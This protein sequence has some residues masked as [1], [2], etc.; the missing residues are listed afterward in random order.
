MIIS[1]ISA[2]IVMIGIDS[3]QIIPSEPRRLA[4]PLVRHARGPC[5]TATAARASTRSTRPRPLHAVD[6]AAEHV[7][8]HE[9]RVLVELAQAGRADVDRQRRCGSA[10]PARRDRRSR[11]S[12]TAASARSPPRAWNGPQSGRSYTRR[13][14][15]Q[16]SRMSAGC[17]AASRGFGARLLPVAHR[18]QRRRLQQIGERVDACLDLLGQRSRRIR[19]REAGR[20]AAAAAHRT[21]DRRTR[22]GSWASRRA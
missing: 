19:R 7:G 16:A 1:R 8:H 5:G 3:E 6:L 2:Q 18:R 11:R 10:A 15:N 4:R 13:I 17:I 20:R 21:R 12:G 9:H 22:T 14:T